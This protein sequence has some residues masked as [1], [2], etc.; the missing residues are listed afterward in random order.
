MSHVSV[1]SIGSDTLGGDKP[2]GGFNRFA[3]SAGPGVVGLVGLG[4]LVGWLV[5]LGCF[6]G[7]LVERVFLFKKQ[8]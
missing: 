8:L 1:I 5:G 3:H 6:V 7:R 4:W 2:L